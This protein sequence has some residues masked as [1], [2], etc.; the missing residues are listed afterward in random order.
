MALTNDVLQILI[1][2]GKQ[3][4]QDLWTNAD[5]Q[6]LEQRARDLAGLQV[7]ALGTTDPQ[8]KAQYQFAAKLVI[9]HVELLALTR[10][11][12]AQSNIRD[13]LRTLFVNVL[14]PALGKLVPDALG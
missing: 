14:I 1:N 13:A 7:K 5:L 4:R 3:L 6:M 9:Q 10:F 12:V 11:D 8:K 2:T